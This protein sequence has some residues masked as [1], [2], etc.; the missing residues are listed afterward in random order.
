MSSAA[1][2]FVLVFVLLAGVGAVLARLDRSA[3]ERAA[4]G[5][6]DGVVARVDALLP[7]TQCAR[8]GYPGC[9]PYAEAIVDGAADIDRC[10]PGGER[11]VEALATLL[12]REPIP[13]DRSRGE[14]KA[15]QVALVDE[16]NCIGCA[17]CLPAC[18][19]D[20]IVGAPRFMHTVV[21]ADCTG[22]ELC[23]P[24]CPVDCISLVPLGGKLSNW[25]WPV[26]DPAMA[27]P[28]A[29]GAE[30]GASATGSG[31]PDTRPGSIGGV[32]GASAG[33]S[34]GGPVD[35]GRRSG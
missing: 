26:A 22:C 21:T 32:A 25:R 4:G 35:A 27:A 28:N 2:A 34:C 9:R 24:P 5:G 33:G 3:R 18:P 30:R 19:V 8:C 1:L 17:L 10:P 16:A 14:R 11:T 12:G 13:L 29:T 23:L 31:G 15:A 7:Q 20:A 6:R